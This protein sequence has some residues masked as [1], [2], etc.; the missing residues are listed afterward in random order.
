M[1]IKKENNDSNSELI[2]PEN[3]YK[4]D[5]YGIVM[6]DSIED[7]LYDKYNYRRKRNNKEDNFNNNSSEIM[8]KVDNT[9]DNSNKEE[10]E[11]SERVIS[12]PNNLQYINNEKNENIQEKN[13]DENVEENDNKHK[14]NNMRN[15]L[16][17]IRCK[18]FQIKNKNFINKEKAKNKIIKIILNINNKEKRE[19]EIKS[20]D[21]KNNNIEKKEQNSDNEKNMIKKKEF[22][23]NNINN[24]NNTKNIKNIHLINSELNN[25]NEKENKMNKKDIFYHV[26]ISSQYYIVKLRKSHDI[27]FNKIIPKKGRIFITKTYTYKKKDKDNYNNKIMSL[28]YLTKCFFIKSKKIINIKS[29]IALQNVINNKYFCTKEFVDCTD[30]QKNAYLR[31]LKNKEQNDIIN[32]NLDDEESSD[33]EEINKMIEKRDNSSSELDIGK[34][35]NSPNIIIKIINPSNSSYKFSKIN[36]KTKSP[37]N[38]AKSKSCKKIIYHK[39]NDNKN[40]QKKGPYLINILKD[41]KKYMFRMSNKKKIKKIT[42]LNNNYNNRYERKKGTTDFQYLKNR[43]IINALNNSSKYKVKCP[44]CITLNRTTIWRQN[45]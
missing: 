33:D 9:I 36:I 19:V 12:H 17:M 20:K 29:R 45:Y 34:H 14:E 10:N 3:N 22:E 31:Y 40:T 1:E 42:K 38:M 21:K 30:N 32:N 7:L 16:K 25:D 27:N 24:L 5:N 43:E 35:N 13:I 6:A 4:F 2:N 39:I 11:I 23:N 18:E 41:N 44:A 26:P 37:D 28:P 15:E 8:D